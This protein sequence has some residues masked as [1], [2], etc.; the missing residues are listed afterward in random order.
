MNF[1]ILTKKVHVYVISEGIQVN[2]N[3]KKLEHTKFLFLGISSE[4]FVSLNK[5]FI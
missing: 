4:L 2:M 1:K 5:S 3:P